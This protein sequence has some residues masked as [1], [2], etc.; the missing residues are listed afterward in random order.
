M[1]KFCVATVSLC[2]ASN[3]FAAQPDDNLA[4][5]TTMSSSN[6]QTSNNS[7]VPAS[8]YSNYNSNPSNS[9]YT[10]TQTNYSAPISSAPVS[11][12]NTSNAVYQYASNGVAN[13]GSCCDTTPA[14]P[15]DQR[16]GGCWCR[17]VHWCPCPYQTTRCV[18]E[19][20][21]CQKQCCRMVPKYY[22]VQQCKY[23]P[24]YYSVTCC[25]YEP[26][27]YCEPDCKTVTRTVCD[28]HC[29]YVP[30][31]YWKFT[32]DQGADAAPAVPQGY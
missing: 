29:R 15:C 5:Y 25:R 11:T 24:Q 8:G 21:P 30:Q 16:V 19:Q 31:Y 18:E 27:Y 28:Q 14:T 23:V 12:Y 3:L 2:L 32:C 26:E 17:Y 7:N 13:N 1:L 6:M 9:E 10:Y 20:I 4:M 22:Q